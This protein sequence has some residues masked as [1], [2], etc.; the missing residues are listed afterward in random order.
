MVKNKEGEKMNEMDFRTIDHTDPPINK[1]KGINDALK[2]LHEVLDCLKRM[3]FEIC[4]YPDSVYEKSMEKN[5]VFPIVEDGLNG[6]R[7]SYHDGRGLVI[8]FTNGFEHP[9][10][11]RRREVVENLKIDGVE[12]VG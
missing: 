9:D 3:D 7:A 6:I 5:V 10:D 4:D 11:P 2:K 1:E 12:V 8:S